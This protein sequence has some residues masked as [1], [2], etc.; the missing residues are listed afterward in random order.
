[1]KNAICILTIVP[2]KIWLEFLNKNFNFY[3]VYMLIDRNDIDYN[4]ELK[5]KYT[6]IHFIQIDDEECQENGY[7]NS[8]TTSVYV[9]F[10]K[11][12]AWDKAFYYFS[13]INTQYQHVWFIEEDVFFYEEKTLLSIDEKYPIS[14]LLSQNYGTNESGTNTDWV[15]KRIEIR[16]PPP[17]YCAMLCGVRISK[18]LLCKINEYVEKFSTLFFIEAMVPTIA[19]QC[20]LQYDTPEELHTVVYRHDW[21]VEDLSKIKLYHPVKNLELHYKRRN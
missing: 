8:N 20:N 10:G 12:I 19:K 14:D 9:G 13:K 7:M 17:Y 4:K 3:D 16:I 21:N 6:N 11:V 5:D 1:M 18:K 2:N 15:W